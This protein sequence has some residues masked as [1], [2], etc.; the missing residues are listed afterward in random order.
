MKGP[1]VQMA[2]F[3]EHALQEQD[4][5][6]SVVRVVDRVIVNAA[7]PAPPETMPPTVVNLKMVLGLKSGEARGRHQLKILP[8]DPSAQEMEPRELSL[9]FE[10]DGDR[11][12]NA[13]I[14]F[15]F[16]AEIEGLYWFSVLLDEHALSRIPLRVVYNRVQTGGSG[17]GT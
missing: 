12:I 16:R 2:L 1:Y 15:S 11:G 6:L 7:G 4:G 9:F 10:G 5:V 17:Q 8:E 13:R 14:N 3:C